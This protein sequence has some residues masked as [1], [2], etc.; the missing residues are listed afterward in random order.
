MFEVF[1]PLACD[2]VALDGDE[3][4]EEVGG[5][6]GGHHQTGLA[7]EEAEETAAQPRPALDGKTG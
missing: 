6:A 2:V 1:N 5:D 7:L 3:E 4:G